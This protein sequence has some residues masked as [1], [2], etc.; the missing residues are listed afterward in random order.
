MAKKK[1][2]KHVIFSD[3]CCQFYDYEDDYKS[4][5]PDEEYTWDMFYDDINA[6]A[7]AEQENLDWQIEGTIV[8]I[9]SLGLWHGRCRGY[10]IVGDKL[11]DIFNCSQD[12]N[13]YY[14]DQDDCHAVCSHHDG[15]NYI[16]YR[17]I[18]SEDRDKVEDLLYKMT[19]ENGAY[20]ADVLKHT[21]SLMPY[22]ADI[23]GWKYDR[24][25]KRGDMWNPKTYKSYHK[26]A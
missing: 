9:A 3:D 18:K 5:Y 12:R 17:V 8:A 22:I 4:D 13:E 20:E 21:H 6:W 10:K 15:T 26:A 7:E 11:N 23:F 14:C 1:E 24:R 2:W 16:T 25:M 19:F